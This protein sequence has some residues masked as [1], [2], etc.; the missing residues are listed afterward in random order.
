[1]GFDPSVLPRP[2]PW[3][4]AFRGATMVRNK[5]LASLCTLFCVS[6]VCISTASSAADLPVAVKAPPLAVP[7]WSWSGFYLGLHGGFGGDTFHY[8][9]SAPAIPLSAQASMNS[10]GF[11]GGGQIG[12]NYQFAPSWVA[13]IE[14]DISASGIWGKLGASIT[15]PVALTAGAGSQLE[16]FGTV[17]GRLGYL[18]NPRTLVYGTAGYAYGA[19]KSLITVSGLVTASASTTK[20]KSGWTAGGGIEYALN[21]WLSVKAEYLYLDLG[22]DTL[23]SLGGG[24]LTVSETTKVHT[25]KAGLN[26]K[27]GSVFGEPQFA[28]APAAARAATGWSG[29]YVGLHGGFGGDK[30]SYPISVPFFPV[31]AEASLNSSGFFGGGQIGYNYQFARSWLLGVEADLSASAIEGKLSASITAPVGVAA[32]AGSELAWFGTV[33]GRVGYLID[34]DTL[35]YG[36]GGYAYGATKSL[37]TVSGLVT[38]A[39]SVTNDKSGWTLGGGVEYALN[40]WLTFKGEY[41]YLD[42]GTSNLIS[43]GGVLAVDETTKVHTIKAG[44]NLKLG[45]LW[46]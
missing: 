44:L 46:N 25:I 21:R 24:A 11:F 34:P 2:G 31:A 7:A 20:D 19:T 4:S 23:I 37:V 13:G 10:S 27:L 38:G 9:I 26:V 3:G 43:I 29:F 8:P 40:E 22:T 14:A 30:F 1:M 16:W 28:A 42:L 39:A 33:R 15:A 12:Y 17:R 5:A 32:S 36:T 45:S 6:T 18:I 35:V 41:L